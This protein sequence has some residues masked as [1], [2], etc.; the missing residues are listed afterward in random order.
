VARYRAE[1]QQGARA[2]LREGLE[3]IGKALAINAG[4]PRYLALQGLLRYRAAQ[5]ETDPG[6]RREGARQAAVSL[7]KALKANP[8][9]ARDYGP[10]LKEARI[11]L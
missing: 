9:L 11:Q 5:E 3:R 2:A 7:E 8:L 10:V 6:R 4:E 1:A